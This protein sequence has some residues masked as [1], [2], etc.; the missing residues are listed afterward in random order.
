MATVHFVPTYDE[1]V[2]MSKSIPKL[3]TEADW[4]EW[5]SAL[6][7]VLGTISCFIW[8]FVEGRYDGPTPLTETDDIIRHIALLENKA[9]EGITNIQVAAYEQ[10]AV[11]DRAWWLSLIGRAWF[12]LWCTLGPRPRQQVSQ[13]NNVRSAIALLHVWH[14][15]SHW[16]ANYFRW[17]IWTSMRFKEGQNAVEFVTKWQKALDDIVYVTDE[18]STFVQ[19]HVFMEATREHPF[20]Q[21][22]RNHLATE[23]YETISMPTVIGRFLAHMSVS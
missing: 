6:R 17:T 11:S 16:Q 9:P 1:C 20:T 8:D 18:V 14:R 23:T 3:R 22:F 21:D 13:V 5:Y 10:A 7:I 15:S 12:L 19:F 2:R 4:E